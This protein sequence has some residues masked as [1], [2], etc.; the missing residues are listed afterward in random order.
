MARSSWSPSL[1]AVLIAASASAA[2]SGRVGSTWAA[3]PACT[4]MVAMVCETTSCSSRAMRSRSS[5]I[6]RW[7]SCSARA[8][9]EAT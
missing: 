8:R 4:L 7:A 6:R 2:A 5:S 9:M 1:L 3:T